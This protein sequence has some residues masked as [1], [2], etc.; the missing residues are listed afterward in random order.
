MS[1]KVAK[2]FIAYVQDSTGLMG[3]VLGGGGPSASG[4]PMCVFSVT[5][6]VR[7]DLS[8]AEMC[9]LRDVSEEI[10]GALKSKDIAAL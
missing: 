9:L 10:Q 8:G 6:W 1:I 7:R 5:K 4:G 2:G 3:F